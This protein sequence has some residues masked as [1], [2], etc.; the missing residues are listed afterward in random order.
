MKFIWGMLI[1]AVFDH[2]STLNT[3]V[4]VFGYIYS[5]FQK[6]NILMKVEIHAF[7]CAIEMS[8]LFIKT[9]SRNAN[10]K[11]RSMDNNIYYNRHVEQ[12]PPHIPSSS[13]VS[14]LDNAQDF[15]IS[16]AAALVRALILYRMF[17]SHLLYC[18]RNKHSSMSSLL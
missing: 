11:W 3:L 17:F 13:P 9:H 15:S 18:K 6:C 4:G 12:L 2:Y 14:A 7:K 1:F 5:L 16:A 10:D 8:H